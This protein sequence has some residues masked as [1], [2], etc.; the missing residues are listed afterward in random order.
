[1]SRTRSLSALILRAYDVGEADRFCVLL[2]RE[3]GRITARAPGVRRLTS[4][5]GASLTPFSEVT[6]QIRESSA[7]NFIAGAQR[8][9]DAEPLG[10]SAFADASEGVELLLRL[11]QDGEPVEEVF[12]LTMEFL[13]ACRISVPDSPVRF[14]FRLLSLLG[15]MPAVEHSRGMQSLSPDDEAFLRAVRDADAPT[16]WSPEPLSPQL[17]SLF[18]ILMHEHLTSPLKAGNVNAQLHGG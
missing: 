18:R 10:L 2:S 8:K 9:E 11:L 14:G 15:L 3:E 17:R 12:T 16:L 7:G 13:S 4:R 5:M 1:M 6:I